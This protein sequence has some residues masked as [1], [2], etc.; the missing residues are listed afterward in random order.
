MLLFDLIRHLVNRTNKQSH[1]H[2]RGISGYQR[3]DRSGGK[4]ND[5]N[6]QTNR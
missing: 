6:K 2:G 5:I 4:M 1:G 3:R